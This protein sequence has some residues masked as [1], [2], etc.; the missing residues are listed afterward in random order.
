MTSYTEEKSLCNISFI[1]LKVCKAN[2]FKE[3]LEARVSSTVYQYMKVNFTPKTVQFVPKQRSTFN[4][5]LL[6]FIQEL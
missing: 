1:R 2:V 3:T 5:N 6:S 4:R